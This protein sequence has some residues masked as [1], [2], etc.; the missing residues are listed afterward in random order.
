VAVATPGPVPTTE[1]ELSI[2]GMSCA[3]CAARIT[4]KLNGLAGVSATVNYATDRAVVLTPA[5]LPVQAVIDE[6]ERAGY[7]AEPLDPTSSEQ[8]E[9]PPEDERVKLLGRR[10][11]V[12]AVLFMPLCDASLVFSLIPVSRFHYWQWVVVLLAAPVV[13][14]AAW[15]IHVAALRAARHGASTMDTLV[16]LGIL[17]STGW[18]MYV[19]FFLHHPGPAPSGFAVVTHPSNGALYLDVAAGVTTFLLAG[20]YYEAVTKRRTGD[21]LRR[22]AATAAKDAALLTADGTEQRVPVSRLRVGDR[23]VVRSG[24]KIAT[25]GL[26]ERGSSTIDRSLLTGESVPVDVEAGDRVVGGTIALGGQ[27]TVVASAVGTGTQLAQMVRLVEEAQNEKASVQRL[28]D[29]IAAVFVPAVLVIAAVTLVGWLWSGS[30]TQRAFS[31]ALAVLIIACPCSLGLAT[32]TALFVAS[33]R[34]AQL[35]IFIKGY[36]ALERSRVVDVVVLDKTGTVT[37]GSMQVAGFCASTGVDRDRLL[38]RI[39][40]VELASEHA[41]GTAISEFARAGCGDLPDV[42]AYVPL[43]GLG[44][45]GVVEG[46]RVVLGSPKLFGARGE[47]VPADIGR[48]RADWEDSGHTTILV[49]V[50]GVV[51]GAVALADTIKPSASEAVDELHG[52][53]LRCILLT[54]D[55]HGAAAVV[56]AAIGVDDVVSDALPSEKVALIRRLQGDGRAVA[57]IGDGVNDGPALTAADLGLAVGGGTD[58][59]IHAADMILLSDSLAVVPEAIGLARRTLRTIRGNLV[60]AFAYNLA[61]IP[62]AAAGLLNPLIAGASMALSSSFVVWNSSRLRKFGSVDQIS[63]GK[64]STASDPARATASVAL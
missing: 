2:E 64:R 53:G 22:L 30:S 14:W 3:A 52:L 48:V 18:S 44:A 10:L 62:L 51:V 37:E 32:P 47:D 49:A 6:V 15:P 7:R 16:S 24:E 11:L 34:G 63:G 4:K 60:W 55:N 59:A 23:F 9:I 54:G 57:F 46:H 19:L 20:R 27:L 29:R 41:I 38:G 28:A 21:V 5:D 1:L 56:G 33:G 39:G 35:G 31:A 61:A 36:Q 26:V 25:D 50:D 17:A 42:D 8:P 12:A 45:E 43:P 13:I 58:V 40:A